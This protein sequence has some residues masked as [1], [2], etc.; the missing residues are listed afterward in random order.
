VVAG[1][2][3]GENAA[4]APRRPSDCPYFA[5]HQFPLRRTKSAASRNGLR[6]RQFVPGKTRKAPPRS[7]AM[8]DPR[9]TDPRYDTRL[10]DSVNRYDNSVGG[11]WGWIAGVVVIAV[12][13]LF[14]IIGGSHINT[15]SNN[16]PVTTGSV[17]QTTP[18]ST[19]GQGPATKFPT[20]PVP[21]GKAT[22]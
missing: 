2:I 22:Q 11:T 20:A 17:H 19:T 12:I 18:P 16:A 9:Y 21:A 8:S 14:L 3:H 10:S 13:A 15:A 5:P 1:R 4:I 6:L 7:I